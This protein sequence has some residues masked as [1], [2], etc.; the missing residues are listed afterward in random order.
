MNREMDVIV[1][2][3]AAGSALLSIYLSPALRAAPLTPGA[4][5]GDVARRRSMGPSA[6][7]R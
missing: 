5:V 2:A 4:R 7:W 3:A 1:P 6:R